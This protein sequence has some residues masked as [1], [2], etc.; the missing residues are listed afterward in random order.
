[1]S[2]SIIWLGNKRLCV[3]DVILKHNHVTLLRGLNLTFATDSIL[4]NKKLNKK[5]EKV[6]DSVSA[7]WF[8]QHFYDVLYLKMRILQYQW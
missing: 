1:M 7:R 2:G 6:N 5:N 3:N 8:H 4:S